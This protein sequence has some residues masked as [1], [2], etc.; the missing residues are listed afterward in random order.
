MW[1]HPSN[2][3]VKR[4]K[5][6][7]KDIYPKVELLVNQW[8]PIGLIDGGAPTDEYDCISVQ[9][10]DLLIQGKRSNEIYEFIFHELDDHFGMGIDSITEEYKEKFIKRHTEFSDQIT[11]WYE[12]NINNSNESNSVKG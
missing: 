3:K 11:N 1:E 6:K 4:L 2:S 9:L 10:I 7:Y 8:D 12:I 5:K